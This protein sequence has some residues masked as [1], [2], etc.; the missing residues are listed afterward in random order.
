[1]KRII[2]I[3]TE[4]DSDKTIDGIKDQIIEKYPE[5][6]GRIIVGELTE[7]NED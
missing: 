1:M 2:T 7:K 6:K 3:L 4:I 5:L